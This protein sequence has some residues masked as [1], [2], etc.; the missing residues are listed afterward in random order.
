MRGPCRA[1][2][3]QASTVRSIQAPSTTLNGTRSLSP[4]AVAVRSF[5]T[6]SSNLARTRLSR[7]SRSSD[8]NTATDND[9][10]GEI[11]SDFNADFYNADQLEARLAKLEARAEQAEPSTSSSTATTPPRENDTLTVENRNNQYDDT[12]K[13]LEEEDTLEDLMEPIEEGLYEP[14][15]VKQKPFGLYD[16]SLEE[17]DLGPT[18]LYGM[19]K[20][21]RAKSAYPAV[22]KLRPDLDPI[23]DE[24]EIEEKRRL[25]Q[26]RRQGE[27]KRQLKV[28]PAYTYDKMMWWGCG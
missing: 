16:L 7:Q 9:E 8:L 1:C 25:G 15:E 10:A 17:P 23:A 24:E 19:K 18:Q 11:D 4:R 22:I 26:I 3:R 20:K 13:T 14:P 2:L 5:A 28:C 6:T 27:K 12:P 21:P